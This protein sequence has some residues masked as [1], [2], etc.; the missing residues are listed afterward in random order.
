MELGI[1]LAEKHFRSCCAKDF[2][3]PVS[4]G[5]VYAA[6]GT[7]SFG[8]DIV[9][10]SGPWVFGGCPSGSQPMGN[11]TL[12]GSTTQGGST[13][14]GAGVTPTSSAP[15]SK[16]FP[17]GLSASSP[18]RSGGTKSLPSSP[19]AAGSTAATPSSASELGANPSTPH[20][21]S[22]PG[23]TTS[24]PY[25]PFAPGLTTSTPSS[26]SPQPNS[27]NSSSMNLAPI[28][29]LIGAGVIVIWSIPLCLVMRKR[30]RRRAELVGFASAGLSN[31]SKNGWG[32][33][34]AAGNDPERGLRGVPP[35][36]GASMM[37][38][39][40]SPPAKMRQSTQTIAFPSRRSIQMQM[41]P[42]P[43]ATQAPPQSAGVQTFAPASPAN[44]SAADA[45]PDS[46]TAAL[47]VNRL[48][49]TTT[50]E[51]RLVA[52]L[53]REIPQVTSSSEPAFID[54]SA[55]AASPAPTQYGL[56]QTP[57]SFSSSS[58]SSL[59]IS[60]QSFMAAD[61]P[62]D[63]STTAAVAPPPEQS[64]TPVSASAGPEADIDGVSIVALHPEEHDSLDTSMPP[65]AYTLEGLE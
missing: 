57:V 6:L 20:S 52:K 44:E 62:A 27:S 7:D 5:S 43:R 38:D 13:G 60:G 48:Q 63:H 22:A 54:S 24:T 65:P 45:V 40:A 56:P 51:R 2:P 18:S 11:A 36:A 12:G 16:V 32:G 14:D 8:S 3:S 9:A 19:S 34:P 64:L 39:L 17:G 25:F 23:A 50:L 33:D 61:P 29:A 46:A 41:P 37:S 35:A 31:R 49:Y 4:V 58:S 15:S 47:T 26:D 21:P 28:D 59:G 53:Q 30:A 1:E 10:S 42:G 55:V